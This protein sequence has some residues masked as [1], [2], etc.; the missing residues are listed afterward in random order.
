MKRWSTWK[1]SL[2]K[3]LANGGLS[4]S[5]VSDLVCKSATLYWSNDCPMPSLS[6][7]QKKTSSGGVAKPPLSG[8]PIKPRTLSRTSGSAQATSMRIRSRP[9]HALHASKSIPSAR[10]P[11]V[12]Q[13]VH[14][15]RSRRPNIATSSTGPPPTSPSPAHPVLAHLP[16]TLPLTPSL[17]PPST[18]S[19]M[20][21]LTSLLTPCLAPSLTPANTSLP[22]PPLI[23]LSIILPTA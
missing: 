11:P 17:T 14:Y 23:S 15:H 12:S 18:H 7:V 6:A 10:L 5:I 2:S 1:N 8:R 4:S 9:C 19:L 16:L 20:P 22:T 13:M 21:F 3:R